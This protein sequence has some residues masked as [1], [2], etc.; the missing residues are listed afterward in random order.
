MRTL[1]ENRSEQN[2]WPRAASILSA[3][4]L[5][6]M[7]VILLLGYLALSDSE[8]NVLEQRLAISQMAAFQ[9]DRLLE[10]AI[11]ELEQATL[12]ADFDPADQDFASEASFLKLVAARLDPLVTGVG[13]LDHQGKVILAYPPELYQSD[14][15][16]SASPE[17]AQSLSVQGAHISTP[18]LAQDE[19]L[20]ATILVPIKGQSQ[21]MGMLA[22]L[23]DLNNPLIAEPL[24]DATAMGKTA[25]ATLFDTQGR[26]IISTLD[27]PPLS[28]GE[29]FTFFRKAISENRPVVE[30]VPFELD[31]PGEPK[32][33]HHIMAFVPLKTASWGVSVGG[34]VGSETFAGVWRTFYWLA[35]LSLLALAL[36][37]ATTML[38]TRRLLSPV[39][40]RL[41]KFTFSQKIADTDNWDE[42][43]RFIV[44]LP[45]KI[46][47]ASV[48]RL[49]LMNPATGESDLVSE[50][51]R[52][53]EIFVTQ[54]LHTKLFDHCDR[55]TMIGN[56]V[57]PSL[58]TCTYL[59]KYPEPSGETCFCLPLV[60]QKSLVGTLHFGL[61]R[62]T[63]LTKNQADILTSI[64]PDIAM[65]IESFQFHQS[66]QNQAEISR[67]ERQRIS[68][69]LHDTLGQS[70]SFLRLRLDQ[71][72]NQI[73][74]HEYDRI[75]QD[76]EHMGKIA[77][78]AYEQIRVPLLELQQ[79]TQIDLA[80]A[81]Q[82]RGKI[83]A[84]RSHLTFDLSMDGNPAEIPQPITRR[85][86]SIC[87]EALTN[88][89]H[90]ADAKNVSIHIHWEQ[91][92]VA[93]TIQDD[94]RGFDTGNRPPNGHI[95]LDLMKERAQMIGGRLSIASSPGMGTT[96]TLWLPIS[97]EYGQMQP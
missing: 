51:S 5:L 91:R 48:A 76:I 27:L 85:V 67:I 68:R 18:Y 37:W 83:V 16:L 30:E 6:I 11:F 74:M 21:T 79:E 1:W 46:V 75:H 96:I 93:I 90:H 81:L 61:Q 38:S 70:I 55:C 23:I 71:L 50:W 86:L 47:P 29:H 66:A 58:E 73:T 94:G 62:D 7:A 69:Y 4:F 15:D 59:E 56:T 92:E 44:S 26:T 42:L 97:L 19:S 17:L 22:A 13:F 12:F 35:A 89:E 43:L 88:I 32:G 72:S 95:G 41:L 80:A 45:S 60:H 84:K 54:S 36:I 49:V 63:F 28:P 39:G 53:G 20:F 78:E 40:D 77:N 64:A 10:D 24:N 87:V 8:R 31:L 57:V 52:E 33:H 25:H 14:I 65:S 3:G 9:I 2:I 82:N 34:D